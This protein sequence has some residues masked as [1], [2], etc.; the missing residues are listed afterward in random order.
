MQPT[1]ATDVHHLRAG[2]LALTLPTLDLLASMASWHRTRGSGTACGPN[3][4]IPLSTSLVCRKRARAAFSPA[5]TNERAGVSRLLAHP[6]QERGRPSACAATI[7]HATCLAA[8]TTE[9]PHVRSLAPSLT[10]RRL[11]VLQSRGH[12]ILFRDHAGA[13]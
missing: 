1:A 9:T 8:V 3:H 10:K 13:A 2:R 12:T 11:L 6:M 7:V 4:T 5:A